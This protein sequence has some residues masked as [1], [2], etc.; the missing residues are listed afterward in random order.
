MPLTISRLY[1][2]YM[3]D[4]YMEQFT[5]AINIAGFI[6]C[7]MND[8][9]G[10]ESEDWW[11]KKN[12]Y[13]LNYLCSN[14][15]FVKAAVWK[16]CRFWVKGLGRIVRSLKHWPNI[17]RCRLL[18]DGYPGTFADLKW[19]I[20]LEHQWVYT[21]GAP[22]HCWQLTDRRLAIKLYNIQFSQQL[23][24]CM[25]SPL[26]VSRTW[27]SWVACGPESHNHMFL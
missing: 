26:H 18:S 10:Q 13:V 1:V 20:H 25:K 3:C 27:W 6:K 15:L 11:L 7:I 16:K 24:P 8:L 23:S 2:I 12:K 22:L 9:V 5:Q 21:S 14:E 17:I 19:V 4:V